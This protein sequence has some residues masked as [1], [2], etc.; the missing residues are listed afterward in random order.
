MSKF[1]HVSKFPFV[2][3][4]FYVSKFCYQHFQSVSVDQ[5][6]KIGDAPPIWE[7]MGSTTS[8]T[9][10]EYKIGDFNSQYSQVLWFQ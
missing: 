2:S 9:A 10:F 4:V 8:K 5:I 3:K 1:S 6:D 7:K